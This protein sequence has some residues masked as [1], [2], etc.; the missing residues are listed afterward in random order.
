MVVEEHGIALVVVVVLDHQVE[1]KWMVVEEHGIA[2]VV[3][4]VLDHQV[5]CKWMMVEEHGIA[6]VVVLDHQVEC[7]WMVVEE[8]GIA[9]V[10]VVL[11]H[12]AECKWMVVEEHGIALVVVVLGRR[13]VVVDLQ[14][15][16]K[17]LVAEVRVLL[18]VIYL[19]LLV[20]NERPVVEVRGVVLVEV[21]FRRWLVVVDMGEIAVTVECKLLEAM[22][23]VATLV[24]IAQGMVAVLDAL[25]VVCGLLVAGESRD[26]GVDKSLVEFQHIGMA[27]MEVE[28]YA[29]TQMAVIVGVVEAPASHSM[30]VAEVAV[31]L[32][33]V[34]KDQRSKLKEE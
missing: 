2:V 21:A 5:E 10:V 30:A 22:D 15:E 11:D 29:S 17:W 1:C 26:A 12:Q 25:A 34:K 19:G 6:L 8:H 23:A 16:C 9:L 31:A 20:D 3:V 24:V 33:F 7:K 14:A 18:V 28:G 13:L 32:E 27:M 4:V